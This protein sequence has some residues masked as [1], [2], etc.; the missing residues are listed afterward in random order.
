MWP[1]STIAR[2]AATLRERDRQLEIQR[3]D[4]ELL[5]ADYRALVATV[6][7]MAT[8]PIGGPL[9]EDADPWKEDAKQPDVWVTPQEG[10]AVDFETLLGEED[11]G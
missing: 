8:R 4:Y 10:E 6:G 3:H 9:F 5:L 11:A 7:N 2:L 1:F